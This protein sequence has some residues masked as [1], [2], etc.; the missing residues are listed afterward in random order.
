MVQNKHNKGYCLH[1]YVN[2]FPNEPKSRNYKLKE[3]LVKEDI[4]DRIKSNYP[5]LNIIYDKSI[6]GGCSARRPDQMIDCYTHVVFG[7]VDEEQHSAPEYS[8]ENKRMMTLMR[9]VGL[10]PVVF[11][12][13]NPDSYVDSNNVK[14]VSP[15]KKQKCGKLVV[16]NQTEWIKRLEIYKSRLQ[17]YLN[18]IPNQEVTIEHLF[19][20]GYVKN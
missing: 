2:I 9:D 4:N 12:R 15:F 7:E 19:Y 3:N 6:D 17:F 18:N 14:H 5:H 1:C 11:I 8:C 10:R 20:D 16:K 13:F